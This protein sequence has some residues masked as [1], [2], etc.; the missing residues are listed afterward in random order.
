MSHQLIQ[1]YTNEIGRLKKFTDATTEGVTSEA[2]KDLL[3]GVAHADERYTEA[4]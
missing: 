3:K 4:P 1:A 2:F